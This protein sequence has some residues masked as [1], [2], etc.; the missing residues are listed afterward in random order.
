MRRS[1][2]VLSAVAV[3]GLI[4]VVAQADSPGSQQHNSKG[5][6]EIGSRLELFVDDWLIDSMR[7]VSLELHA[8]EKGE[9]VF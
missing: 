2:A 3:L 1:N 9:I 8:P 5:V 7:D 6:V 4:T